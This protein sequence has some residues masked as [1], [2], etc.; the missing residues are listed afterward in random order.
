M[1]ID[2]PRRL[3]FFDKHDNIRPARLSQYHPDS[4]AVSYP[5][6]PLADDSVSDIS[7]DG[8]RMA[9]QGVDWLV[10]RGASRSRLSFIQDGAPLQA[11]DRFLSYWT[12][13]D[14]S[15]RYALVS[16][17]NGKKRPVVIDLNSGECSEPIA[18]DADARFGSIDPVQG[19]LWA[20]D[21][22]A[23]NSVLV[24]DCASG[25]ISKVALPLEAKV[26]NLRF[27]RDGQYLF[28][29]G[30]NHRLLCC[31]R[32]GAVRWA[33]DMSEIG[34]TGA[35][36]IFFNESGSHLC[37]PL[38]STQ[39]SDWGE[40]IIIAAGSGRIENTVVRQK[41]PPARLAADWFGDRL[42]THRLEVVDF[43]TGAVIDTIHL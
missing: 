29:V 14:P 12:R 5:L 25:E 43:F 23:S 17:G 37:L 18:R 20:P 15:A 35:G 11:T 38:S 34:Q 30:E 6:G 33:R 2:V 22:R 27:S 16:V 1:Y 36:K 39:R 28:V 9:L 42:L 31:D 4:G 7:A 8:R 24:V 26:K 32:D 10:V 21:E 3:V 41:G 13:F 19:K 40:D